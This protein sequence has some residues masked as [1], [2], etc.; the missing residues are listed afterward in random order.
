MLARREVSALRPLLPANSIR[1]VVRRARRVVRSLRRPVPFR[2]AAYWED[3]YASG[4]NSGAGSYGA[5]AA[6]KA[7]VL[8]DLVAKHNV[9]TVIE[10]GCGD[11]HQLSLAEYPAYIGYD[12]SETVVK[13]CRGLFAEDDTKQFLHYDPKT[14]PGVDAGDQADLTLSLEVIFHLVEDAVFKRHLSICSMPPAT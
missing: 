10:F 7:R 6:F 3:R 9:R 14:F 8:N 12:V 5:V 13:R 2:S 1:R 11:G 4:G